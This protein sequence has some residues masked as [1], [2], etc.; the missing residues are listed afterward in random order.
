M[1]LIL[2]YGPPATGKLTVS[3]E[4]ASR[5]GF[6]ILHNHKTIDLYKEVL[7][8]GTDEFWAKVIA[9]RTELVEIAAKNNK[10]VILTLCYELS[11]QSYV[12][13]LTRIVE[14]SGSEIYFVKLVCKIEELKNRVVGESRKNHGKIKET[15]KLERSLSS[16]D[17]GHKIE[18]KHSIEIENTHKSP[19]EVVDIVIEKFNL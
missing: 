9:L 13:N 12:D 19:A 7:D 8:F 2:I 11:D 6:Y 18:G 10:S 14:D 17:Y 5:T 1:K 16:H 4:L 15:E 3:T